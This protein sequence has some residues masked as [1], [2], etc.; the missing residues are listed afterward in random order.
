MGYDSFFKAVTC[1]DRDPF[2]YQTRLASKPWPQLLDVP[3]GLGKTAAVVIAWLF[4][5]LH[6]APDASTRLVYC[7]PMRVLV[8]QTEREAVNW[9]RNAAPLFKERGLVPPTV[10]VL[11]GGDVDEDWENRPES[12]AI[13]I[14]TQDML[15]SRALNRGYAQSR[16]K[17]PVHFALLN[18][19]CTWVIDETQLL[20]VGIET[21]AQLQGLRSKIGTH[22][23]TSTLWMS[24]TLGESQ[25]VT[26]DHPKP[27]EGWRTEELR[28]DDMQA[29]VVQLRF[30]ASKPIGRLRETRLDRESDKQGYVQ[31]LCKAVLAEHA[32][33]GGLTLVIVNRVS[34]AQAIYRALLTSEGRNGNNT[35][36]VHSRFRGVDRAREEAI[37][38]GTGD[39][40]NRIV[41][42]TQA[43]EAGVDV[44]AR[45]LFT[46]LAPWP[47]LVQ[48]F[49]RCNRYG[50]ENAAIYW[51]DIDT[52]DEKTGLTLPYEA[53]EL[54]RARELLERL[55]KQGSDAGPKNLKELAY[56]PRPT[57]RPVIR[58]RDLLDLFD[59]TAD[60]SGYDIDVSRY[61]RDGEDTDVQLCWRRFDEPQ[62]SDAKEPQPVRGELCRV[63]TNAAREFLSK[64]EKERQK[65]AAGGERDRERSHRF[66]AWLWNPLQKQWESVT[67][68]YSGQVLLLHSD[69][70]GYS[71]KLGWTGELGPKSSVDPVE[72]ESS[73][74]PSYD[75]DPTSSYE[76]GR[77]VCLADHLGHVR[78]EAAALSAATSATRWSQ[79]LSTAGLWHDVGK[80]HSEFQRRMLEP[81]EARPELKP[82]G[83]GP[84][85][86]SNH[87]LR[88]TTSD[89]KH[90]RH[91]L[92]SAL[93]WLAAGDEK[94]PRVR[95]LVAYLIAA[96]HG[97]VRMSLRALPGEADP[98]H[99]NRLFARGVQDGEVLPPFTLPDG[100]RFEAVQLDLSIMQI[101]AG[102]WLERVLALRDAEDIGPFRLAMLETLV[103]VADW[104]ASEKEQRGGYDDA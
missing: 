84:W 93:A 9:C 91:E 58:R 7:L 10:H 60:L 51:L 19:D 12:P 37:L 45:A 1:I 48:R 56:E 44:S 64:L 82:N 83:D 80:A 47:S 101:G 38:Q 71:S 103:R 102:S 21:S 69:A 87:R 17:W 66:R 20:G 22:Q 74:N 53:S 78:D 89:R 50:Q 100:R 25:L 46:E 39:E 88:A 30:E 59:T 90:F 24:A 3:T 62:P 14:G 95:D 40:S 96:H 65:L 94:K 2:P 99:P 79:A 16:Y 5:R 81:L 86:K 52:S 104:R 15:L 18:N 68:V 54:D 11:M 61:V 26:V 34:R 13:L 31:A 28:P 36:L 49:G 4:K 85:A 8:Q 33:R 42:A 70:G 57:V 97:K 75:G 73:E 55:N 6:R 41:V 35:G 67:R 23:A 77:W 63:S 32:R 27:S 29:R 92:A 72:R 43:V 98:E 76:G